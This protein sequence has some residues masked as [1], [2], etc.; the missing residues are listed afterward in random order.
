MIT[1]PVELSSQVAASDVVLFRYDPASQELTRLDATA[2]P[3]YGVDYGEEGSTQRYMLS[4]T[5]TLGD[6]CD[7]SYYIWR[8]LDPTTTETDISEAEVVAHEDSVPSCRNQ[9]RKSMSVF[10][11][12]K[13]SGVR[14]LPSSTMICSSDLAS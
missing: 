11:R 9:L 10:Q 13:T 7:G 1:I 12:P 5:V 6:L 2:A 14:R 3:T 8:S 4:T